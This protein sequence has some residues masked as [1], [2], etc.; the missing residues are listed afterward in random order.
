MSASGRANHYRVTEPAAYCL[1]PRQSIIL[2]SLLQT[3]NQQNHGITGENGVHHRWGIGPRPGNSEEF[4]QGRRQGVLYDLNAEA[5]EA[6]AGEFG[7]SAAWHAGDV[8]DEDAVKAA[9][10]K[11]QQAFGTIHVNVNSAGMEVLPG[12]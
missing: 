4:R 7:E 9:I 6:A 3:E 11:A 5:L 12:P 1:F 2:F 10:A 8:A